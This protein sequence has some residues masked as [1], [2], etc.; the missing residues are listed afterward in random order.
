MPRCSKAADVRSKHTFAAKKLETV[1][2]LT[3][4]TIGHQSNL[5][6]I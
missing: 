5:N 1:S 3:E 6:Q 2:D 4:W